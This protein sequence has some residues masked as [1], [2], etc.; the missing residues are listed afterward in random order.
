MDSSNIP[1]FDTQQFEGRLEKPL[2]R[3]NT[4]VLGISFLVLGALFTWKVSSLQIIKGES[5]LEL[6]QRNSLKAEPIFADR[7]VIYDRNQVELAWNIINPEGEAYLSRSYT[8]TPG[9]AHLLGYIGYPEKDK[10]GNYWQPFYLG[11][12]G[13]EKK[14]DALLAG[15]NG[16][17]LFE[18][19]ALG[20]IRSLNAERPPVHGTNVTL[21]IDYQIQAKMYESIVNLADR[22]GF[23]GGA[24]VMMD[25]QNGEILAITSYP[26]YSS[27]VMSEGK[28]SA[29]ITSYLTD[30]SKKPF[31]N[32]AVKGVYTPGSIIKP[33]LA[34]G[35]L[36]EGIVDPDKQFLSTGKLIIPNPYNPE[37]ESVFRDWK[38]EGHG[39]T[40]MRKGIAESVNTYFYIIGGGYKDQKGLGIANIEKYTRMFGIGSSI[41]GVDIDG[42][43][44]GNIPSPEWKKKLFPGD[45]WRLGDTYHTAIGQ[46]GFQVTPIQM[47]RAVGAIAS[48]GEFVT[49]HI[50]KEPNAGVFPAQHIDMSDA[51]YQ[52]VE[53]GMRLVV[54]SG[55]G[56]ALNIP[57]VAVAAKTGTAQV[58]ISKSLINSWV[59]GFFPYENP[60][61][62][63]TVLMESSPASNKAGAAQAMGELMRWMAI[64]TPEYLGQ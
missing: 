12:D 39:Y 51:D 58:G 23:R 2:S 30:K 10:S 56:G 13:V 11:K 61:Y 46:Y 7:G 32:R 53:D 14:Y 21:T 49:P 6:S 52:V 60:R 63:F 42:E 26:E 24:G 40:D 57:E 17:K 38:E 4:T 62:A 33:F 44:V 20:E 36:N 64:Y 19:D 34:L 54:T 27:S 3:T 9:F 1:E 8:P 16:N 47:V 41:T 29:L 28:E 50:L 22:A 15:I 25:I 43:K 35:A 37:L 55:T 18:T 48:H 45:P 5:F 59:I 31:L